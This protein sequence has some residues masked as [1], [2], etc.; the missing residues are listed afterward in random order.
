MA[1]IV[2]EEETGYLVKPG[3]VASLSEVL[4]RLLGNSEKCRILGENGRRLV[5]TKY[6]WENVGAE[7]ARNIVATLGR[8]K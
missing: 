7:I 5:L 2:R 3:D 1:D 6:N 4:T 8:T